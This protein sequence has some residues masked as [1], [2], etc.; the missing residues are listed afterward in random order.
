MSLPVLT[1]SGMDPALKTELTA[2][3][4]FRC[5]RIAS[6]PSMMFM[7]REVPMVAYSMS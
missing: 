5:P 3:M 7:P 2:S 4:W 1:M 6:V